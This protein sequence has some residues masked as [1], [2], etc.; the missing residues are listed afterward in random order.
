MQQNYRT[1]SSLLTKTYVD[2]FSV[3]KKLINVQATNTDAHF[4]LFCKA[5]DDFVNQFLN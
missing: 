2:K 1:A 3:T 5:F 4:Q